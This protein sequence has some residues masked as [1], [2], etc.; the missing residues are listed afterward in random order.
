MQPWRRIHHCSSGCSSACSSPLWA[1]ISHS[2]RLNFRAPLRSPQGTQQQYSKQDRKDY[3][4][5]HSKT[6]VQEATRKN[7]P[8][9]LTG[10]SVW[11]PWLASESYPFSRLNRASSLG[12]G[13]F[14]ISALTCTPLVFESILQAVGEDTAFQLRL[15]SR[16]LLPFV[17]V[18]LHS[19]WPTSWLAW[20]FLR[21]LPLLPEIK[22]ASLLLN[23]EWSYQSGSPVEGCPG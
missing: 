13:L 6:N 4:R 8:H 11:G 3:S 12:S 23:W 22:V 10:R 9:C 1:V 16:L 7:P 2:P 19:L 15:F 20:A 17:A 18:V 21:A 14:Q 5:L